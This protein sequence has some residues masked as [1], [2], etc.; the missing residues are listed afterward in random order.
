LGGCWGGE[1]GC[2]LTCRPCIYKP[3]DKTALRI[4]ATILLTLNF[5]LGFGQDFSYPTVK[6]NGFS[7]KDFT[8]TAWTILDS[9]FGDLNN[10]QLNDI[11]FVLQHKDSVTFIK[12][13][14]FYKENYN[15]T[16]ITQ[17]R[18]LAIVVYNSTTKQYDLI[19]QSNSFI[20]N[21]DN[22][23]MDDPF[24]DLK[25]LNEILEI[26]FHIWTSIGSWSAS[27]NIYNF[28]FQDKE[29]KLIGADYFYHH[30]ATEETEDRS[31][32]FL[33]KKVKVSTGNIST[34]KENT[35]W[36]VFEIKELKTFKT[37]T[38]P[39]TWEIEKDFYL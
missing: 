21:H 2:N 14:N 19:E 5:S 26:D 32:N 37:F 15:D 3:R 24:D 13:E 12:H 30:R 7:I 38:Q 8:P 31:Y 20:L 22:P 28:R 4:I 27:R 17:P 36:R 33:T 10:D 18:I 11:A 39:F 23:D 35:I 34:D 16:I 25:I 29:F 1:L 9:A 6:S